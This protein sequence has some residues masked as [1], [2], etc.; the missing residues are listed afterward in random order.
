MPKYLLPFNYHILVADE[1]N[2]EEL[3]Y[4]IQLHNQLQ[5]IATVLLDDRSERLGSKFQDADLIGSPV[6]IVIGKEFINQKVEV[7]HRVLNK[8][9][10]VHVNELAQVLNLN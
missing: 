6:V 10:L 3:K 1:S 2:K 8:K 5:Q 9:E 4:G 7:I